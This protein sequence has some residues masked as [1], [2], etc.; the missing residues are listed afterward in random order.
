M[1]ITRDQTVTLWHLLGPSHFH[2]C[3]P[4]GCAHGR[5]Q[6]CESKTTKQHNNQPKRRCFKGE[7]WGALGAENL[8]P[9][10][11]LLATSSPHV[12]PAL[13]VCSFIGLFVWLV[14][15]LSLCP[16]FSRIPIPLHCHAT[17]LQ[18]LI[19]RPRLI[20]VKPLHCRVL[21]RLFPPFSLHDVNVKAL[22]CSSSMA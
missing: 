4:A 8:P 2:D 14:V 16:L 7:E 12:S 9:P 5:G 15:L 21:S 11:P 13:F 20:V 1:Y 10:S 22:P 19:S 3:H 17:S 6:I 18:R